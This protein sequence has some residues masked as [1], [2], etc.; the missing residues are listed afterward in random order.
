MIIGPTVDVL[1]QALNQAGNFLDTAKPDKHPDLLLLQPEDSISIAQIRQLIRFL[2]K[3][4]FRAKAKVGLIHQAQTLTLPA[5]NA[6]LK[7]LEEPP[8]NSYLILTTPNQ[9][10]LIATITSRCQT[11][12]VKPATDKLS[13]E[14]SKKLLDFN[15]TLLQANHGQRLSLIQKYGLSRSAAQN[16]ISE[17]LCFWREL[18]HRPRLAAELNRQNQH[19]KQILRGL[20]RADD[21]IKQ[22]VNVKLLLDNLIITW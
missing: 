17:Q 16:F 9:S 10:Q 18:L 15:R 1:E 13:S 20:L 14:Q 19:I 22:N 5:Q 8:D 4:P 6:L 11:V 21:L 2:T 7:T 3:K 12:I